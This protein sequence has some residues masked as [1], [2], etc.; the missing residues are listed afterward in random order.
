MVIHVFTTN[1]HCLYHLFFSRRCV[2]FILISVTCSI[3]ISFFEQFLTKTQP[4]ELSTIFPSLEASGPFAHSQTTI[5]FLKGNTIRVCN[6]PACVKNLPDCRCS[7]SYQQ[8]APETEPKKIAS[9]CDRFLE[10]NPH[11]NTIPCSSTFTISSIF[12]IQ[13]ILSNKSILQDEGQQQHDIIT[14]FGTYFVN[15]G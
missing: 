6:N 11:L 1:M 9:Q 10:K 12:K 5:L 15:L 7:V 3:L 8:V 14:I 4:L 13:N 2:S